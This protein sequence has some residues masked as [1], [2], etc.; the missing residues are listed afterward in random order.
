LH[1]GEEAK[2]ENYWRPFEL[3]NR[4]RA[5]WGEGGGYKD[6]RYRTISS[7]VIGKKKKGRAV[8]TSAGAGLVEKKS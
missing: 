6:E 5:F 7:G 1:R 2:H 3:P 4:P 8:S